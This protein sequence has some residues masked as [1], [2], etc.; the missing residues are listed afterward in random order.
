M[1]D[2][3]KQREQSKPSKKPCKRYDFKRMRDE[4]ILIKA[5]KYNVY[6]GS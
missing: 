2:K 5:E 6:G 4:H 3:T 1:A